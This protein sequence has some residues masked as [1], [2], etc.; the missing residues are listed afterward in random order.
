MMVNSMPYRGREQRREFGY[1]PKCGED[2]PH[3]EYH[4]GW[5]TWNCPA[6]NGSTL[7]HFKVQCSRCDFTW[8]EEEESRL[9]GPHG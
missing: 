4:M 2:R 1:C 5:A 9:R 6:S 3:I 8:A 7:P